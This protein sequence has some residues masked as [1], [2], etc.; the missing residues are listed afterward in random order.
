MTPGPCTT[1]T[2]LR[3]WSASGRIRTSDFLSVV[4]RL[5]QSQAVRVVA[6]AGDRGDDLPLAQVDDPH[7]PA[8]GG[9]G[10]SRAARNHGVAPV[11][12]DRGTFRA[13]YA[14][15]RPGERNARDL[16]FGGSGEREVEIA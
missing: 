9:G 2:N 5:H 11:G 8:R 1:S 16:R 3:T 4:W 7:R 14:S 10:H 15:I 13:R 12:C 6:D